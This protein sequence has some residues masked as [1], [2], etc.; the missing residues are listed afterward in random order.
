MGD[1][2]NPDMKR[3]LRRSKRFWRVAL[4]FVGGLGLL[5]G[6]LQIIPPPRGVPRQNPWRPRAGQ[7]PLIIAHGGGQGLHPA[8][9]LPSFEHSATSGCDVLEMD[10]RL[11]KDGSLVTHHDETIDRTSDGTGRVIDFTLPELKSRNFGWKF[12]DAAGSRPYG[13]SPARIA[14]IDEL[15]QRFPAMPMVIELKDRGT[16]GAKAAAAL[17]ASIE[18]FQMAPRVIIASFDDVTLAEF[19]RVSSNR[20]ATAAAMKQTK[21]FFVWSRL[22][23]DWFAPATA[24]ALQIPGEKYG[25]RLDF[26]GLIRAAHRRN[27]AVH[28]WTI[29]DSDEMKRLIR[30]GA[31]GIMTDHPDILRKALSDLGY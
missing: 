31:D 17:A 21:A 22:R 27:M 3:W 29:N 9:T 20:V 16:N 25:Y 10:L 4:V 28:Y 30:L 24:E 6:L 15:F 26:P 14:T 5:F 8:N 18:R 19:Q 12:K 11:T 1:A 2:H 23:L 7:R 13:E